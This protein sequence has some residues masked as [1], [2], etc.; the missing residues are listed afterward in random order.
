MRE[1]V[2]FQIAEGSH[3]ILV[4][5]TTAEPSTLTTEERNRLVTLAVET[6]AGRVPVVAATG[7]QS[8]AES[9]VLTEH[10]LAAG[11]DSL[12]IVTPYYIRPPQRGLVAYYL[13]LAAGHDVPWMI[14]HIPGRTAVS[15]TLDTL[16]A[17]KER[18]PH[19]VGIKQAVNDLGFVSECLHEFGHDFKV[20][21]GLEELS[22]PMMAIGACGLMNAV[23]NLK[24]KVLAQMCEAVFARRSHDGPAPARAAARDQ[25]GRVLRHEPDSDE[26]HDEEAWASRG[27]RAPPT[28]GERDTGARGQAR[29]RA[30]ARRPLARYAP[31]ELR[32]RRLCQ[33]RRRQR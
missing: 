24:P 32:G 23:G 14:Y 18:S 20:F 9:R 4:N 7:S 31:L 19:F 13:E 10:A 22:F 3:G 21:V 28:D 26:V 27:Q 16:K 11:A 1:L 6:A 33:L 15:V 5:G 2:E 8:L 30:R 29:R 17:V 12:L 25:Q